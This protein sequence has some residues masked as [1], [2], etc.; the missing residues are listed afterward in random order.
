MNDNNKAEAYEKLKQENDFLKMKLMLEQGAE[1]G[2]FG[3]SP[4]LPAEAENQFLRNIIEFEK[5]FAEQ[6]HVKVF[7]RI[8]RPSKFL[9]AK[10]IPPGKMDEAWE[11]LN[12]YLLQNNVDLGVCS[13][14]VTAKELYRFVTE[15]L[16]EYEMDD[17]NVP[18]MTNCFIYD[19]FHPDYEYENTNAAIDDCIRIMLSKHPM[20]WMSHFKRDNLRLN[21]HFPLTEEE[22][23][24]IVNRFKYSYEDV[25]LKKLT[26]CKCVIDGNNCKVNGSY[27]L[28]AKTDKE[29]IP[30]KGKWLVELEFFED[31]GYWSI[32]NVQVSAIKF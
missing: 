22:F 8:G 5:Q 3:I 26:N 12:D 2:D 28:V 6:K 18:G 9:P 23:K 32:I 4:N 16:F 30:F 14:N 29:E 13:P 21:D 24:K 10:E 27:E 31:L 11:E 19:E 20:D 25:D 7:E 1:F 15:E 17:M